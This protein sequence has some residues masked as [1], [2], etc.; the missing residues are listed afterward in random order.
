MISNDPSPC[1]SPLVC[2][3]QPRAARCLQAAPASGVCSSSSRR[4]ERPAGLRAQ[5]G[6]CATSWRN[7]FVSQPGLPGSGWRIFPCCPFLLP[8]RA[9]APFWK[10]P[11]DRGWYLDPERGVIKPP[12]L[13][14]IIFSFFLFLRR[15]SWL[16]GCWVTP[17]LVQ[18]WGTRCCK[19]PPSPSGYLNRL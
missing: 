12:C 19:L 1:P 5:E 2:R 13:G 18:G 17:V 10:M 8:L 6:K 7:S 16:L 14:W 11:H 15:L 3:P 9:F 4:M